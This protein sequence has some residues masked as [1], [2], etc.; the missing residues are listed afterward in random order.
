VKNKLKYN[1]G[2]IYMCGIFYVN[3]ETSS[4]PSGAIHNS[5][6]RIQHRGPDVSTLVSRK[7]GE[8]LGF[9]RLAINGNNGLA[10]QPMTLDGETYLLCNGEIYNHEL[11]KAKYNIECQSASDC[12]IILHLYARI[13]FEN[14][15]KELNGEFAFILITPTTVYVARDPY[16][17]RALYMAQDTLNGRF[18]LASE[19]KALYPLFM[20]NANGPNANGPNKEILQFPP[21]TI[22]IWNKNKNTQLELSTYYDYSNTVIDNADTTQ[23]I[24]LNL[25]R[26]LLNAVRRRMMCSRTHKIAGENVPAIG[27]YLS[28]GFDSSAIAAMLQFEMSSPLETFSIGFVGSPDLFYAQKVATHIGSKHHEYIIT[29]QQALAAIPEVVR[30]IE[31]YDITTVRAS[32]MM[33]LLSQYVSKKSKVVVMF[34]GEG[35]DEASG[36]YRY[37]HNAPNPAEFQKE[38]ERLLRDL[39]YFD[40]LRADKSSAAWGLEVRVPFLDLEFLNY[41]MQLPQDVKTQYGLEKYI[42]RQSAEGYLPEDILNRPKEAMSD[43]VSHQGRSWSTIIQEQ[44][45]LITGITDGLAAEKAYYLSLFQQHYAGC[46]K[47]IPYYWLPKWCGEVKDPSARV[48][49]I[50]NA[51]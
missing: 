22:G 43:G 25:R 44:A 47:Q 50:Y 27:A 7:N 2:I 17:V 5:F 9:H 35:S 26:L 4:S 30:M 31:S 28:G 51:L 32:T 38:A 42:L 29:E 16:G 39:C 24:A 15:V 20:P 36:S 21:G 37:F 13:G 6:N 14:T 18:G 19:C 3:D 46:E 49:S 48:L 45:I 11:L 23:T 12:E 8:H 1:K 34:S 10:N 40:N 41:Y 33:Y